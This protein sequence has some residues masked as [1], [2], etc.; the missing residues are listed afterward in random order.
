MIVADVMTR[1]VISIL[2]EATVEEAAN[3]MLSRRISGLFVVDT[4]GDLVGVIT[5]GD[6]LRRDELGTER[7][8]PWWLRLLVS[9]ARQAADF[10]RAHGR[11][12]RDV[13]TPDV[14]SVADTAPLETVVATMERARIKRVPVTRDG[15]VTGVVSRADLLRALVSRVKETGPVTQDDSDIRTAILDDLERQAW[16]PMTT[17]NVTVSQGVADIWGTITNEEERH[18]IRVLVENTPGVAAVQDHLVY[19]EPYT[20]TVIEGPGETP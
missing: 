19:I 18:A 12:V 15:H 1:N 17:L 3:L 20:G 8:R 7:G 11:H 16:A 6:L 14:I 2:P 9:P 13:M 4:A 5:E 10:T